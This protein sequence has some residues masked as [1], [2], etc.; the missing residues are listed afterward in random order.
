MLALAECLRQRGWEVTVGSDGL[1][2][3]YP[4]DQ[5]NQFETDQAA[6]IEIAGIDTGAPAISEE[7]ADWLYD[8]F[9]DIVPCV[10]AQGITVSEPPSRAAFVEQTVTGSI[11]PW[12]PYDGAPERSDE[13]MVDCP[14]PEWPGS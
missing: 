1:G 4:T 10:E 13:L 11:V 7:E 5:A 2:V 8:A 9:L 12:H 6:C 3:D 14:I